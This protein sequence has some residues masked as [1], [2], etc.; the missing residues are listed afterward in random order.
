MASVAVLVVAAA[1]GG[2]VLIANDGSSASSP[3]HVVISFERGPRSDV[4]LLQGSRLLQRAVDTVNYELTLPADIR[5]RMVGDT[6]ARRLSLN[7]P[8][9]DPHARTVLF[10]WSFV[11]HSRE[12]IAPLL[13]GKD[14]HERR[15]TLAAAMEFALYH[16]LAHG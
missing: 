1:V 5:V 12:E 6:T 13:R 8:R 2:S 16:E 7:E 15:D 4:A 11:D 3:G 10:P 14:E 9:Y